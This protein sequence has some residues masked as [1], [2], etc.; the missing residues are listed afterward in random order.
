[1]FKDVRPNQTIYVLN[2]RDVEIHEEKV[3]TVG[4]PYIDTR[5]VGNAKMVVDVTA[6]DGLG[7]QHVYVV[8]DGGNIAFTTD[9]VLSLVKENLIAE[10]EAICT[11]SQRV[12][13]SVEEHKSKLSRCKEL[14]SELKP[15]IREKR[16]LD[17]RLNSLESSMSELKDMM[18]NYIK[19]SRI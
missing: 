2:R 11:E 3:A 8:P 1:M 15:E 14:L 17:N 13:D 19:T 7:G 12:V 10:V 5:N 16:E 6:T 18:S 4:I 9:S